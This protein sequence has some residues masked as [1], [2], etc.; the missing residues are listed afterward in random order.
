MQPGTMLSSPIPGAART[1]RVHE[2]LRCVRVAT[3]AVL[4][5]ACLVGLS[6]CQ[7]RRYLCIVN[8]DANAPVFRVT[9]TEGCDGQRAS[10]N[11]VWF[12]GGGS[13]I[14]WEIEPTLRG[15]QPIPDIAFGQVPPGWELQSLPESLVLL[16][17]G[18]TYALG[19]SPGAD[20][21][22]RVVEEDGRRRV[23]AGWK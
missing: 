20:L 16:E 14:F 19:Q 10:A 5:M 23:V 2:S 13:P 6:A 7:P 18:K 12:A 4:A 9:T 1:R 8:D 11:T 3:G 21:H 17:V 22:F 15:P